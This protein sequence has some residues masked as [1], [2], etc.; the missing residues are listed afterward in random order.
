MDAALPEGYYNFL[1]E[2]SGIGPSSRVTAALRNRPQDASLYDW[3]DWG[4]GLTANALLTAG[5]GLDLAAGAGALGSLGARALRSPV[6]QQ[7][8]DVMRRQL[9]SE[10]GQIDVYHGS[11]YKFSKFDLEKVGSGEG[12]QAFGHGLYF[13][14]KKEI[15][16]YYAV[17]RAPSGMRISGINFKKVRELMNAGKIDDAKRYALSLNKEYQ[18]KKFYDKARDWQQIYQ[19]I[20]TKEKLPIWAED[21]SVYKAILHKGKDP[22]KYD[23]LDWYEKITEKQLDKLKHRFELEHPDLRFGQYKDYFGNKHFSYGMDK[24]ITNKPIGSQIYRYLDLVFDSEKEASAFLKRSGIDGITYPSETLSGM[25]ISGERGRNYVVFDPQ[26][27]SIIPERKIPERIPGGA[28]Y[29]KMPRYQLLGIEPRTEREA[30]TAIE[31]LKRVGLQPNYFRGDLD[32]PL[33]IRQKGMAKLSKQSKDLIKWVDRNQNTRALRRNSKMPLEMSLDFSTS[34]PN[35][36]HACPYCYVEM[37]RTAKEMGMGFRHGAKVVETPYA[38]EI[39]AMPADMITELNRHGGLRVHGYGDFRPGI[40]DYQ[41]ALALQDAE[42]KGLYLKIITKEPELVQKFGNHPNA[43]INISLDNIPR[44]ISNAPTIEEAV[45]L[46]AGRDNIKLRAVALNAKEAEMYAADPRID[47]VTL[48][49]GLVGDK[50]KQVVKAQ[51]PR[52]IEIMGEKELDAWLDTWQSMGGAKTKIRRRLEAKHPRKLCCTGGRCAKDPTKCGFGLGMLS[53]ILGVHLPDFEK[54]EA[55][56][57]SSRLQ[58]GRPTG[59][60]SQTRHS[61]FPASIPF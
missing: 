19:E 60:K 2:I 40:D 41:M 15:A 20:V 46:K 14:S 24:Q 31:D 49:H 8:S 21:P 23:Y 53:V 54:E 39:L 17:P 48:Y 4:A 45:R 7:A 59:S 38:R 47:V 9:A 18:T 22:S 1:R 34:C 33:S 25:P 3:A 32:V 50:L 28:E 10:A 29:A 51:N 58:P 56:S 30:L 55:G 36:T 42:A 57:T 26:D 6:A 13:T 37:T 11:P 5:A 52:L 16:E 61:S 35:R 43:R 27:I 44:Q 12:A